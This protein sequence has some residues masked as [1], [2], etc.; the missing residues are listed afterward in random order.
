VA[1]NNRAL[2]CMYACDLGGAIQA[3]LCQLHLSCK[4]V[5]TCD[6]LLLVLLRAAKLGSA[7]WV[8]LR[9]SLTPLMP[10]PRP[11]LSPC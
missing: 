5:Y 11:E 2:C 10:L 8:Q 9:L 4:F 6:F 1:L 7:S 3:C